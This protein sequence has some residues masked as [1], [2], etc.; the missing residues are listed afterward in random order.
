MFLMIINETVTNI[1]SK[2]TW[3]VHSNFYFEQ[4]YKWIDNH[5][6]HLDNSIINFYNSMCC[7]LAS[8]HWLKIHKIAVID[9]AR[10]LSSSK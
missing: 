2:S 8:Y 3:S 9:F 7:R 10:N 4:K 6:Y 1:P 5:A